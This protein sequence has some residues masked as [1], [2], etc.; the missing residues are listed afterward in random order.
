MVLRKLSLIIFLNDDLDE[1]YSLPNAEKGMLRLYPKGESIEDV[2]DISPRLGRAV[3][4][5]SEEM[6]HQVMSSHKW[7]NY[8]VTC[9]F[10]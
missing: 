5:K 9:Y 8:A 7:D 2:V 10:N 6:L 4:F 3:L 1:V